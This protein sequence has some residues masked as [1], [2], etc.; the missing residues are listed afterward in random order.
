VPPGTADA[1]W[2]RAVHAVV[3]ELLAA[4]RPEV[5]VSQHGADTHVEDSQAHLALSVDAQR[6]AAEAVHGWAH[7]LAEGRWLA[8]GGGGYAVVDVVPR[9]WTHV[10]A[11][12]AHAGLPPETAVPEEF[13]RSAYALTRQAGPL[14]MTD[15]VVPE[16][17]GWEAGYDPA[18]AVD[19]AILATRRA[20]FPSHG[21]LP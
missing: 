11:I 2:L 18:D 9:A 3:P 20:V 19:R 1:A 14:R 7:E 21:L 8:L 12:A 16:W 13:R 17:R 10:V 5:L 15:G 6:A 4:F